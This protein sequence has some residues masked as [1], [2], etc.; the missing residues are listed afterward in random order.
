MAGMTINSQVV[1][2]FLGSIPFFWFATKLWDIEVPH[3]A[4]P[5]LAGLLRR[6]KKED[7]KVELA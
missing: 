1:I 3:D 6:E 7:A 5:T 4:P 2:W